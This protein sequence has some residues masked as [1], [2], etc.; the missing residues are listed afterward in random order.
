MK[1][2]PQLRPL[3]FSWLRPPIRAG[4]L[5]A[6]PSAALRGTCGRAVALCR[7]LSGADTDSN[8]EGW[9]WSRS[10]LA[11]DKGRPPARSG[12]SLLAV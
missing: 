12:A 5:G 1:L 6:D 9:R 11:T 2:H 10:R 7:R 3:W 8:Q 4:I